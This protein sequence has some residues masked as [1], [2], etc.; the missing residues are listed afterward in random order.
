MDVVLV[1]FSKAFDNVSHEYML[2][3]LLSHRITSKVLHW[4]RN[5][6]VGRSITVC[7]NEALPETVTSVS[8]FYSIRYSSPYYSRYVNELPPVLGLNCLTYADDLKI[9]MKIRRD[10]YVDNFQCFLDALYSRSVP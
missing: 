4:I 9:W 2:P 3:N 1:S 8:G 7:V 5:L 10:E 6:L